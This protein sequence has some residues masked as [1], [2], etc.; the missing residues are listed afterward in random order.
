MASK[1]GSRCKTLELIQKKSGATDAAGDTK[2]MP[3]K[4]SFRNMV[5]SETLS[6]GPPR[7]IL[8]VP[9]G[10]QRFGRHAHAR[11]EKQSPPGDRFAVSGRQAGTTIELLIL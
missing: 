3:V 4:A 7:T 5:L 10:V 6:S 11:E 1:P 2:V 9:T 8:D